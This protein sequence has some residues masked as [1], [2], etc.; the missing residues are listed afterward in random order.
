MI[1]E[2]SGIKGVKGEFSPVPTA[3]QKLGRR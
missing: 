1:G 2:I 3:D